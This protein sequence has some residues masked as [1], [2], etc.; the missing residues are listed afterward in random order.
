MPVARTHCVG[1][2]GVTGRLVEVEADV[3]PGIAGT[4]F[5]GLLDT[6]ISEARGRV[7][8]AL[9]NSRLAWPDARVTV[10]LFPATLPKRGS[11]FDL[12]KGKMGL[13]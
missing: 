6:A 5:I 4:H 8:S 11:I 2:V 13:T 10:S 1:L 7:R 3:G 12:A 9:I